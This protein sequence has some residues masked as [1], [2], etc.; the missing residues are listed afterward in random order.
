MT[1]KT[2]NT[3]RALLF[4]LLTL[5]LCLS[6]MVG[7][8]YAWFTDTHT[9]AG[10]V[11][12]SG[13]LEFAFEKWDGT[14]WVDATTGPIFDYALWEPGYTQIVNL[15]VRNTGN[16]ALK[17]QAEITGSGTLSILADNI[18]VYVRSDDHNDTVKSYIDTV[19]RFGFGAE[20]DLGNFKKFTLRQF[21]E[22]FTLMTKGTL[23]E[24]QESYLG[25]VLQMPTSA[26]NDCRDMDLG[27]TF[28]IT[29]VATQD[30]VE[31]D[32]YDN[33]YDKDAT[34]H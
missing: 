34:F 1:K 30:T 14:N 17:W 4:S 29:V 31:S 26:G 16:L 2:N 21:I 24:N 11:I 25:I 20:A 12:K 32:N 22:N 6:M 10:N 23:V 19:D 9:S 8:T 18:I 15:R 7:S 13:K 5:L 28:N 27:G 3:K 33:Q